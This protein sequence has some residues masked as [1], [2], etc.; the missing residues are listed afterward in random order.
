MINK[1]IPDMLT[2][3][4]Y[5]MTIESELPLPE[6]RPATKNLAVETP[7]DVTVKF[8]NVEEEGVPGGKQLGPFLWVTDQS[9]W[10]QV[11]NVARF[12]ISNGNQIVIDPVQGIDED[13]IRVFLLGSGLGVLLF[14][15]GQLVLH[16]NAI[17]IA[18]QSMVCVGHSGSGKSALAAGFAKRGY[19]ILADDVV[20]VDE[21]C[22]A[23]SGF[24]RL[25]LWQDTADALKIDT[26]DLRRVRPE[27]E[28]FNY[29][30]HNHFFDQSLPIR[31]VYILGS[32][33][34]SEIEFEAIRGLQRFN[35]LRN[36]TYR[37]RFMEGQLL[38][39]QHLK[40][41]GQLAGRIHLSRVLRP[42]DGFELEAL[43][44]SI[45]ADIEAHQ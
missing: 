1:D 32:H 31:W 10:L 29:P 19:D 38:K 26:S 25:K 15:R 16:G 39:V 18:D 7:S 27:L 40:R 23:L 14:Q 44:D 43:I 28:K 41:C 8:A 3:H 42:D 34:T 30:I 35:A 37:I 4:C 21:N 33:K 9:L 36:N 6:L 45:L 17:R 11:P 24:P 13:S 5:G 20:A 12:L 2:Y 22:H